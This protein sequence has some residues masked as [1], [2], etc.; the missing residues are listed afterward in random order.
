M[1]DYRVLVLTCDPYLECLK[2]FAWLFNK[3]WSSE[4]PVLVG[5]FTPPDFQLPDNFEFISIGANWEYPAAR[6]STGLIKFLRRI[7]D[8]VF[9][10]MLEDQWLNGKVEPSEI[11]TCIDVARSTNNLL[12]IDMIDDRRYMNEYTFGKVE[13]Y[14]TVNGIEFIKSHWCPYEFAIYGTLF[15]RAK[16]LK[17]VQPELDPWT[18]ET[19]T[20]NVIEHERDRCVVLGTTRK[21]IPCANGLRQQ[22]KYYIQG[23]RGIDAAEIEG[24]ITEEDKR[25]MAALGLY[26]EERLMRYAKR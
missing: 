19:H 15:N 11:Q 20:T 22:N 2:P 16:M 8:D 14:R 26:D 12:R 6:Y 1:S 25:E 13:P 7:Q 23:I 10:F 17:Y 24:G 4:Q 9:V 3:Y 5:G 21:L 18:L